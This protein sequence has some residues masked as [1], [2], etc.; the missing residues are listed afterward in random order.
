VYSVRSQSSHLGRPQQTVTYATGFEWKS[1][2]RI[3]RSTV[4]TVSAQSTR[5]IP[6]VSLSG[7]PDGYVSPRASGAPSRDNRGGT[8]LHARVGR[9]PGQ[10]LAHSST[11]KARGFLLPGYRFKAERWNSKKFR[12]ESQDDNDIED[13]TRFRRPKR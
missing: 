4:P 9:H 2:N 3:R 11:G 6:L 13:L 1:L 10:R 12:G 5:H 7:C 8:L